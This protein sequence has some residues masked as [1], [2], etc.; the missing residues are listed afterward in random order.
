LVATARNLAINHIDRSEYKLR[1]RMAPFDESTV[2]LY[3]QSAEEGVQQEERFRIFCGAVRQ[4]PLQCRRAFIL[5]KV[6]GLS[7]KE[8]ADYM[9]ITES[10]VQ[11]HVAKGL[12]LCAEYLQSKSLAEE[13]HLDR[14]RGQGQRREKQR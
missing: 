7:R 9:G 11:K 5:K 8:I 6:Y 1:W 4:L 3:V 12:L 10:T 14:N 2:P 13:F